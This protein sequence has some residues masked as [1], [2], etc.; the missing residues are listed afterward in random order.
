MLCNTVY[1]ALYK[2]GA[3]K[4]QCFET[5]KVYDKNNTEV[6]MI[7]YNCRSKG[8][9]WHITYIASSFEIS[10]SETSPIAT[11]SSPLRCS[12]AFLFSLKLMFQSRTLHHLPNSSQS[13]KQCWIGNTLKTPDRPTIARITRELEDWEGRVLRWIVN[14]PSGPVRDLL[15]KEENLKHGPMGWCPH[16]EVGLGSNRRKRFKQMQR[17]GIN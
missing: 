3:S 5:G 11:I 16:H 14:Y 10:P 12:A 15:D 17:Q 13:G 6:Q 8:L 2:F 4:W 9:R 1:W 7:T